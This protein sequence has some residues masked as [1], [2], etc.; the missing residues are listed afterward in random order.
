MVAFEQVA[1]VDPSV[2]IIQIDGI[3]DNFFRF[4]VISLKNIGIGL[5]GIENA[6]HFIPIKIEIK[7][8][9]VGHKRFANST[10]V[11]S[12]QNN[13]ERLLL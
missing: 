7:N 12:Y 10:L 8:Q 5:V 1:H 9:T 2:A 6:D 3:A 4:F 11:T 13:H